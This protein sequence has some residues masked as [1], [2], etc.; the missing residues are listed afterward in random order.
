MNAINECQQRHLLKHRF[1]V[2]QAHLVLLRRRLAALSRHA[3]RQQA[4]VNEL[5]LAIRT[6]VPRG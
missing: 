6:E 1:G 2:E 4:L 3:E 5:S